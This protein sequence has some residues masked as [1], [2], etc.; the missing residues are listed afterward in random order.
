MIRSNNEI[1]ERLD[2]AFSAA[3]KPLT[4]VELMEIP[5]VR[6]AAIAHWGKDIQTATEKLSDTLGFMWRRKVIERVSSDTSRTRAR[7]AYGRKEV[8]GDKEP[9]PPVPSAKTKNKGNLEIIEKDGEV[10]LNF[11]KFTIVIKPK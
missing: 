3:K 10:I 2:E 8:M 1:Y 7:F 6:A 5:A 4:C 11:E 9:I